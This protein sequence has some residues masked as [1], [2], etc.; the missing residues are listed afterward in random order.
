M[1]RF[2]LTRR[3]PA[4]LRLSLAVKVTARHS[5]KGPPAGKA[6]EPSEP[7]EAAAPTR[8]L[9]GGLSAGPWATATIRM[10]AEDYQLHGIRLLCNMEYGKYL[11]LWQQLRFTQGNPETERAAGGGEDKGR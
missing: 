11:S 9:Q 2:S 10:G 6:A 5:E 3:C 8:N 1:V 4:D 7:P